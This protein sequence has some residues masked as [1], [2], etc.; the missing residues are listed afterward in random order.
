MLNIRLVFSSA[1]KVRI[2]RLEHKNMKTTN[3]LSER[4]KKQ[5][6]MVLLT[7]LSIIQALALELLWSHITGNSLLLELTW[8]ALISWVQIVVTLMGIILIWLLFSGLTMRFSWVPSPGDSVTPFG[9]G[10]LEFT[11]VALLGP[12][13]LGLWFGVLAVLF[14][15]STWAIQI[16]LRRARKDGYNA[17][18][19][20]SVAPAAPRD[21]YP[22]LAIVIF[23]CSIGLVLSI[24]AHQGPF[25]LL[26]LLVAGGALGN[27]MRLNTSR[28]RR[29]MEYEKSTVSGLP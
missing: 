29:A 9:I 27:Q 19:F 4:A 7:L 24:T 25:A 22:T 14:G 6:P 5:M 8:I 28:W 3:N 2:V 16:I 10:I 13:Y 11:L 15:L 18:F 12:T 20:A 21:F 23:F 17:A 1:S 26:A